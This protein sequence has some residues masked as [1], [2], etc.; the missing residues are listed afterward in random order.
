MFTR[1]I[2]SSRVISSCSD[3]DCFFLLVTLI[4]KVVKKRAYIVFL[5]VG[6]R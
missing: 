4:S 2:L 5:E 3:T 1:H 6:R